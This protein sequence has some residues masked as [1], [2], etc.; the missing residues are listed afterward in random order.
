MDEF[1]ITKRHYDILIKQGHD[2]L[3]YETGGFLGG[4]DGEVQ[5]I[6]PTFNKHDD[7][8]RDKFVF[9]SEDM[10]RAFE[11]FK[12]HNLDYIGMYHTHP[13]AESYPSRGDI[14]CG[15]TCH[16]IISYM[17]PE[18]PVMEVYIIKNR[19][20][21]KMPL[22]IIPDK[23]FTPIDIRAKKET[24]PKDK[25]KPQQ[26]PEE[27]RDNLEERLTNIITDQPNEYER[28]DPREDEED[29]EFSTMV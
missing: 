9:Y 4:I 22:K 14:A 6:L 8:S 29:S 28:I 10:T 2:N 1:R 23:Q 27:D 19:T 20:P 12:K 26:T 18:H 3:P 25:N 11:L 21:I 7:G 15:Q 16:F 13:E 5:A 17:H 24:K